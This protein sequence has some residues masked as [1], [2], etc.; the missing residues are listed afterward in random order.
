MKKGYAVILLFFVCI[1]LGVA[2]MRWYTRSSGSSGA[3]YT[4]FDSVRADMKTIRDSLT[5]DEELLLSVS[6]QSIWPQSVGFA[7]LTGDG[8]QEAVVITWVECRT[9]SAVYGEDEPVIT[10]YGLD[11]KKQVQQLFSYIFQSFSSRKNRE[12]L[13]LF[14]D[15]EG[16]YQLVLDCSDSRTDTVQYSVMDFSLQSGEFMQQTVQ[17]VQGSGEGSCEALEQLE[18]IY[19]RSYRLMDTAPEYTARQMMGKD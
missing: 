8:I 12:A 11:G 4:T 14:P 2:A 16:G 5:E 7:D 13:Y 19:N 1:C 9:G 10:V 3:A 18:R 17:S 6:T 15:S